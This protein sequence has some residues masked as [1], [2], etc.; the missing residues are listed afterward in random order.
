MKGGVHLSFAA[1][2]MNR[3]K[4]GAA[5]E[6]TCCR[7]GAQHAAPLHVWARRVFVIEVDAGRSKRLP[8]N[9]REKM[10][11]RSSASAPT[12]SG[13]SSVCD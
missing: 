6:L 9:G 8:Y 1:S 5:W 11:G 2:K 4:P 10:H 3:G 7:V 12:T 13:W